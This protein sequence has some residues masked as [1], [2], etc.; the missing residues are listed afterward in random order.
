V[1]RVCVFCGSA[2]G[3][4]AGYAEAARSLAAELARRGIGVV[5]GGGSVGLMGVVADAA[6]AAGLEVVGVIPRALASRE[7]AHAGLT[8][9]RVVESMH[10]RKA[11]MAALADAFVALP[12][13]VGTLE[14]TFEV[15]SWAQLG[16]HTK[17]IGVLDVDGYWDALQRFLA[18]TVRE[19]FVRAEY[20]EL[21]QF[22]STPAA[23][24]D[25]LTIWRPPAFPRPWLTPSQA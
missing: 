19:G 22:A 23:L 11:Q 18:H 17:P 2:A 1:K 7:L 21:I 14:E 13:G 24:L 5:Y 16:I 8:E 4:R 6:L 12:G 3:A 9:L 20:L 15:L 25:G 10:E